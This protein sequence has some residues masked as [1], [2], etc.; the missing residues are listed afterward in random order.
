MFYMGQHHP[1]NAKPFLLNAT[2]RDWVFGMAADVMRTARR[3]SM[4]NMTAW[5]TDS[6]YTLMS[7]NMHW[8]KTERG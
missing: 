6:A 5:D 8:T 3:V 1:L 7:A 4:N 2:E